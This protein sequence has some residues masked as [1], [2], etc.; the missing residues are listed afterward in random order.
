M[1]LNDYEKSYVL[2]AHRI[3]DLALSRKK[4]ATPCSVKINKLKVIY[5]LN[6]CVSQI[7]GSQDTPLYK[8]LSKNSS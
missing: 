1:E 2:Q 7:D 3:S 4:V 5:N 8:S 6:V